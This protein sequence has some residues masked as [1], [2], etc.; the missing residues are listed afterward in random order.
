MPGE[1]R[2]RLLST[3]RLGALACAFAA[4]PVVALLVHEPA[5][6]EAAAILSP[7]AAAVQK[8]KDNTFWVAVSLS[9]PGDKKLQ[10][11]LKVELLDKDGR[12]LAAEEKAVDQ[13]DKT[14]D[15]RFELPAGNGDAEGL[16]L[17]Y[18]FG[19]EKVETELSKILLAKAH[20]TTLATSPELYAGS[21]A[22]LRC[23]VHGVRSLTETVPLDDRLSL[24]SRWGDVL[25]LTCLAISIGLMPMALVPR[26]FRRQVA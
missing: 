3:A 8:T 7:Q 26:R 19:K 14:A 6:A 15:Y 25:G 23:E 12:S 1:R 4:L 18:S 9:N 13:A 20:E 11:T 5:P 22:A 2:S 24:Y 17:R 16:Q 21:S 10:G